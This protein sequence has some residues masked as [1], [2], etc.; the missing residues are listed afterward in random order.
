MS[1]LVLLV[2]QLLS[3]LSTIALIIK[4]SIDLIIWHNFLKLSTTRLIVPSAVL[5]TFSSCCSSASAS[6]YYFYVTQFSTA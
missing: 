5:S 6:L 1:E 2:L 3:L 4:K